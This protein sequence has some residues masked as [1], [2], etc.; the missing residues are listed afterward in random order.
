MNTNI[1]IRDDIDRIDLSVALQQVSPQRADYALRYRREHDQRLSLAAWLLLQEA[2]KA[3]YGIPAVPDFVYGAHGKPQLKGHPTIHFNISHCTYAALCVV[4]DK[5][6]G[7]DVEAIP[8]ELDRDLCRYVFNE[9]EQQAI[10]HDDNP[11]LAFAIQWTRKE[12]F[13]KLTG[14]GLTNDLPHILC[15]PQAQQASFQTHIV[16]EKS[17]VYSIC[18]WM[19]N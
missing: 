10:L 12:A 15:S 17:Y 7:C 18:S 13:L 3:E 8:E 2:L 11:P 14:E 4:S 16:P 19:F 5:P 1:Y 6:V 9:E